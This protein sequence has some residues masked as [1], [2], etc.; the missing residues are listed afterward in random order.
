MSHFL[1][2]AIVLASLLA[3]LAGASVAQA[4]H[5]QNAI[6]RRQRPNVP[7]FVKCSVHHVTSAQTAWRPLARVFSR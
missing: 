1:R 4:S 3:V 7:Y 6:E 5:I 2:H